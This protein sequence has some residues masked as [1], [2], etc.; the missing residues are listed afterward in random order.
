[1]Q[2]VRNLSISSFKQTFK[3]VLFIALCFVLLISLEVLLQNRDSVTN[4]KRAI[5]ALPQDSIDIMIVGNS[6]AYCTFDPDVI[7][8]TVPER[9]VNVGLPDAKI[10]TTYYAMKEILTRQH[11]NTIV[12]EA[13][14]FG[15]SNSKYSGFLANIDSIDLSFDKINACFEI[16]PDK[17]EAFRMCTRLYRCHNN[18]KH[19]GIIKDNLKDLVGISS[20]TANFGKGFYRIETGMSDETIKKYQDSKKSKFTPSIDEYSIGFFKR[21]VNL[22]NDRGIRLVVAMAPM[23][24]IYLEKVNYPA[25]YDKMM[26]VCK[27]QGVEYIDFNMLYEKIGLTYDDFEDAFHDAQHTNSSGAEK[28]SR[29]IASI[30]SKYI[31]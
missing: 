22:C 13:F 11:P 29:Y 15:K 24:D 26:L 30:L 19:P 12:L 17:L 23:N 16:F 8:K 21:I 5:L 14:V 20:I 3:L 2:I 31:K 7:E 25:I 4:R 6:H 27:E 9:I 28:V 10:D 1:M 18:W